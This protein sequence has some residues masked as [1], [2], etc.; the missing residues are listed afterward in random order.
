[1]DI[2]RVKKK[3][4]MYVG[5][6]NHEGMLSFFHNHQTK[7]ISEYY[8]HRGIELTMVERYLKKRDRDNELINTS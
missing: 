1:M 4:K 7:H 3:W 8:R 5:K 2:R 6:S